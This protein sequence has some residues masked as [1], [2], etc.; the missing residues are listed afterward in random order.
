MALATP[1]PFM[2]HD[3]RHLQSIRLAG[4]AWAPLS[5]GGSAVCCCWRPPQSLGRC[6][7]TLNPACWFLAA[8]GS[9]EV[10]VN[11]TN[12]SG[13][14]EQVSLGAEY[15]SQASNVYTLAVTKPRPAGRPLLADARL[16]QLGH[17]HQAASSYVELVRGGA[18]T[19]SRWETGC[20]ACPARCGAKMRW[21]GLDA[22]RYTA[23]ARAPVT[24]GPATLCRQ[25]LGPPCLV[26]RLPC[27]ALS[28]PPSVICH[29]SEDGQHA[30]S[31]ELGWRRLSDPARTASRAVLGQLG[32]RLLSAVKYVRRGDTFD[33]PAFPTQGAC[34]K[35]AAGC[36]A[37]LGAASVQ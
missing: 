28:L 23:L 37:S 26:L 14:A 27:A 24:V 8:A 16:H 20:R 36:G 1:A 32:D 22:A 31:Y 2:P 7:G 15:G 4:Q 11:L 29:C 19:L 3:N 21:R 10:S 33:D 5:A 17:N 9:V 34:L 18:L 6:A 35:L 30:V 25:H 12:P 13:H